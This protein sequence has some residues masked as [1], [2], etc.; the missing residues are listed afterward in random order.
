MKKFKKTIAIIL[1]LAMIFGISSFP[2]LADCDQN[3]ICT[4]EIMVERRF[5]KDF[6]DKQIVE[7]VESDMESLKEHLTVDDLEI[8]RILD[9][10]SIEYVYQYTEDYIDY[11][12]ILSYDTMSKVIIRD[13]TYRAI[14]MSITFSVKNNRVADC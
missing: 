5:G 13:H 3:N 12:R 9:D 1:V 14:I 8:S 4:A 6:C 10:G 7:K 11:L 2:A